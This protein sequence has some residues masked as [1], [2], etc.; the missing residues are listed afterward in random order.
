MGLGAGKQNKEAFRDL[1]KIVT[2][3]VGPLTQTQVLRK[4]NPS[5][6]DRSNQESCSSGKK[7]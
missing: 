1:L 5:G 6:T 4:V 7:F 3:W 2:G